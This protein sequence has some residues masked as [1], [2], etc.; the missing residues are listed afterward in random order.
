MTD[1]KPYKC[2]QCDATFKSRSGL[3][4]HKKSKHPKISKDSYNENWVEDQS[5]IPIEESKSDGVKGQP[6]TSDDRSD[7][8]PSDTPS[9]EEVP[10]WQTFDFGIEGDHTEVIPSALKAVVKQPTTDPKSKLTK[11]QKSALKSQNLA[12]LKMGL[13]GIDHVLTK[14]GQAVILDPDFEIK[15]SE[16]DKNLVANAQWAWCEEKGLFLTNHLSTGVIASVLTG[17]YVIPPMLK[18]R[19]RSKRK[20][21][22]GVGG[23]FTRLPLIGRFFRSRKAKTTEIAQEVK[24]DV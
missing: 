20:L 6:I 1:P 9:A 24:D 22:K 19:K 14:Y 7:H 17:W 12:I 5:S 8:T 23:F 3:W 10:K 21:L 16:S 4:K 11:A 18:I 2:D 13:T 15:H